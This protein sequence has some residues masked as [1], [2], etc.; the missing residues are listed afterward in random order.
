MG[1]VAGTRRTD[2]APDR[3]TEA[4]GG[5]PDLTITQLYGPPL[6]DSVAKL[7][8]VISAKGIVFIPSF[9]VSPTDGTPLLD[10]NPFAGN[11]DVLGARVVT[12]RFT[13]PTHPNE[14]TVNRLLAKLLADRF[15]LGVGDQV[16]VVSFSQGQVDANF[17]AID[18]PDVPA[19]RATLVGV[20]ESPSEFDEPSLQMVFAPSFLTAHPDVG[21]VQTIMAVTL[22]DGADPREVLDAVRQ[23]PNGDGAY[24][25]PTRVVSDSARRAVR[26]QV[27]A[28]WLVSALAI[29]AAGVVIAQ[30]MSRAVRITDVERQSMLALGWRRMDRAAE[31]A[32][33]GCVLVLVAAPVAVFVAYELS[34]LFPLGVLGTFEPDPGQ[35]VDWLVAAAGAIVLAAVMILTAAVVGVRR[36]HEVAAQADVGRLAG[37]LSSWGARMPLT[38]GARFAWSNPRGRTSWTSL[39]AGAIGVAGLVGSVTVG[40]TLTTIVD[41]PDRWGV[42]YDQLFGNPYTSVDGDIVAP[43]VGIPDVVAV[44][45]ANFGS[46][47]IDGSDTAT[48]GF[49]SAKGDLVPTVI[50][51]RG[52]LTADE[53]GIGAEV[54]SRLGVGIGDMV[55]AVGSSGQSRRLTVVGLVVTAASAG[56]GAAMTFEAY[57]ALNPEATQNVVLV[58]FSDDAPATA[59]DEVAAANYSPPGSM[60][61]P[62][63]VRALERVTAAPYLLAVVMTLLLV[64]VGAYL[65]ATSAR[66]RRRDLSILRVL[67]SNPRQVR[68]VVHWQASLVASTIAVIGIP[69]GIALGH[70]IVALLTDA[71]GIVPGSNN[72][73]IVIIG[74]IVVTLL[75]A[76]VL[77][78]VPARTAARDRI[79]HLTLDR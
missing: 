2:S 3:Y 51:G 70:R 12:G 39:A 8:G 38:V 24:A 11:D 10:P 72:P 58:N 44:T 77:A 49:F 68:A 48:V 17:D 19:F 1:V 60:S 52:P 54:A 34:A 43:I 73:A 42:N 56:D 65:A 28:L 20:T 64:V 46:V 9:I 40:M 41:Q 79:V 71:L 50:K 15:G 59:V 35:R 22:A 26:F 55:E 30:I 61:T 31:S 16:D 6:I 63:S 45:G 33:G 57:Q 47:T 7:P 53:I 25:V 18:V 78:F 14:F 21:V 5:D 67:G 37:V 29:L 69:L 13:D 66:S 36:P 76:N 27:T 62:T 32:L 74:A 75:V 4:A 23:L